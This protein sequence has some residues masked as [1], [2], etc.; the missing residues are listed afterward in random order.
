MIAHSTPTLHI[1]TLDF[2]CGPSAVFNFDSGVLLFLQQ[3]E[4]FEDH[5]KVDLQEPISI[6]DSFLELGGYLECFRKLGDIGVDKDGIHVSIHNLEVRS[7]K[8]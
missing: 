3:Q 2:C 7:V 6:V 5:I 4:P 8:T 1:K